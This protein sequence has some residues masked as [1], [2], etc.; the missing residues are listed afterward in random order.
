ME[1]RLNVA[2]ILHRFPHLSETFIMRE[3]YWIRDQGVDIN[4]FSLL[5][6]KHK[7]MHQ[8]A[9]ELLPCTHYSPVLSWSVVKAQLHFLRRSPGRYVK[10]LAKTIRH[11]RREPLVLL[12]TLLLFAK[13]VYFA[14][15]IEALGVDHIH[16]HF[17][18]LGAMAAGIAATLLNITYTVH[19]HAFG[20]FGRNQQ[21]VRLAL[22]DASKVVTISSYHRAYVARLCPAIEPE[23]VEIVHLGLETDEFQ[24]APRSAATGPARILSIGRLV[25]K[26]GYEILIEACRLL[27]AQDVEFQCQIV[28][29]GPRA[30]A[31][32]AQIE[33]AG[34]RDK[35]NL[36]GAK[37]QTQILK[38]Y[39]SSDIFALPCVSARRGDQDGMPYVLIEAMA[40]GLPVV[41]TPLAGIPDLVQ[42]HSTG[43]LVQQRDVAGLTAAL[44]Q[45]IVDEELRRRL[46]AQARQKILQ[47]FQIQPNTAKLAAIFRQVTPSNPKLMASA[48]VEKVRVA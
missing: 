37:D 29:A 31:L 8:Q 27:A 43:L 15:Q 7:I 33:R 35:I 48:P 38:L 16:A 45:L 44:Q 46:G 22:Q 40:C 10:A 9:A 11:T 36:L 28:G 3:L 12:R 32:Q 17:V 34:L 5:P 42:H 18:W 41:T 26:K 2:Y 20:L 47:E 25:E 13:S 14:Q 19:P 24:P 4:I 21:D 23:T 39:Q 1:Q 6:P 30:N